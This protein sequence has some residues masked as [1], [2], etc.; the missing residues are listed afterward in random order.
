MILQGFEALA[1]DFKRDWL[2]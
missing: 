2:R 1:D